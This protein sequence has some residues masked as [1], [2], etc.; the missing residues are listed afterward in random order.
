[1]LESIW[2]PDRRPA[3]CAR[4]DCGNP[5]SI[6][7]A[8]AVA[9]NVPRIPRRVNVA[10]FISILRQV[11]FLEKAPQV[12]AREIPVEAVLNT[13]ILAALAVV[14]GALPPKQFGARENV[15]GRMPK[16]VDRRILPLLEGGG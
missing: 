3:L 10:P 11:G 14:V 12:L 15:V 2:D 16:E 9:A 1:M 6:A 4:A 8:A 13:D 5:K 7:L